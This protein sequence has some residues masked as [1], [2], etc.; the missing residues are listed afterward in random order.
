M[1]CVLII[2][3]DRL[4]WALIGAQL[5][6]EGFEAIGSAGIMG[7]VFQL[8]ELQVRPGVLIIDTLQLNLDQQAINLLGKIC[9]GA[10]LILIHGAWDRPSQLRWTAERYELSKPITI[11][12]IV[13]KVKDVMPA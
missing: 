12:Q 3:H 5:K 13:D 9:P 10:P 8:T 1:F 2:A 4:T 11:G 6:E 7:A